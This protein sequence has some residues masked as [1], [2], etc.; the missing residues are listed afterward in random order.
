MFL[1]SNAVSTQEGVLEIAQRAW[2]ALAYGFKNQDFTAFLDLLSE[3]YTFWLPYGPMANQNQGKDKALEYYKMASSNGTRLS[4]REPYRTYVSGN[5]VM[6]EFED[7]GTIMNK[8][9]R[10]RLA[11]S[12]D[13]RDGKIC[14]SREY[15]GM[16]DRD[17]VNFVAEQ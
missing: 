14:G 16:V 1:E 8:A 4:F 13:I 2:K 3:D 6:F 11:Y 9:Y 15:W 7:D 12:F 17:F 5:S 10:N